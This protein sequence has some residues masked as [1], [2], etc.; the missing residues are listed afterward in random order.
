MINFKKLQET[1]QQFFNPSL[2]F[3]KKLLEFREEE[4]NLYKEVSEAQTERI[5]GLK[6]LE[7]AQDTYIEELEKLTK[8][9]KFKLLFLLVE[10]KS[11][12]QE[13]S[14]YIKNLEGTGTLL[15]GSKLSPVKD[16][17]DLR[18]NQRIKQRIFETLK[19]SFGVL[20]DLP[21]SEFVKLTATKENFLD[22]VIFLLPEFES[23]YF[24]ILDREITLV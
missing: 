17:E 22:L 9:L 14:D 3:T 7:Q 2:S 19:D 4:L 16:A 13:V 18:V 24:I 10:K 20:E 6:R 11:I 1:L 5:E 23:Y 15:I 12:T 21:S 8:I